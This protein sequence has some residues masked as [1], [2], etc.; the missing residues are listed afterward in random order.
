MPMGFRLQTASRSSRD[1]LS[2]SA[3]TA[4]AQRSQS[5]PQ[6]LSRARSCAL[7]LDTGLRGGLVVDGKVLAGPHGSAGELSLLSFGFGPDGTIGSCAGMDA[8]TSGLIRAM[9]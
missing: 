1:C 5:F 4:S 7:I 2:R 3:T 8:S 9:K 6:A